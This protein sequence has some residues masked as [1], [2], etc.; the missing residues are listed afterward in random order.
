VEIVMNRR[1]VR[2]QI[3]A[4]V[5]AASL[6]AAACSA[7]DA[8]AKEQAVVAPQTSITTA[9]AVEQPIAR[10]I[11]A[12]GTLTAEDQADV[13]AETAGRVVSTP[14]ERGSRVN[15]GAELVRVVATETDAQM[16]EAEANAAQIAARLGLGPDGTFDVNTVPEVQNAKAAFELAQGEFNRIKALLDQRVVSQSEYDQRRTQMEATRQQYEAAK[17]GAAQQYQSLQAARAR[18]TL[19]RKALSDTVVRAP[20]TG[21]VAERLVSVGDYVTRGMKVAVVVRVNP[22]RVMLTIPE[23]FVSVVSVGQPVDFE[24]DAYPGRRFEGKVK[25]VSPALQADRRAL[26]VEAVVPNPTGDLKPGL[27]ATARLE[28]RSKTPGILVPASAVQT[29]GGTSRVF[30]LTGD[31]VDERIVTTGQT[32]GE[33]IEI[34]TGVTAGERVATTNVGKLA[35]GTK[36]KS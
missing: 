24:V 3:A 29:T 14:I 13:A 35:D 30:V 23:Q 25:F 9:Q 21:V 18:V 31:H 5:A 16:K 7:G 11:R 6:A 33:Q 22:L 1:I 12:T 27:F 4:L 8:K 20:F 34:A 26:T 2:A 10:F 19:A 15:Q 17:N 28:Q 36:V 32:V